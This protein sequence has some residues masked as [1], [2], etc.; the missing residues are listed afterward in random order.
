MSHTAVVIGL[1]QIGMGYDLFLQPERY[2]LTH[3]RAFAE[4]PAFSLIGGVDPSPTRRA[5][6]ER[7]YE[8]PSFCDP[9]AAVQALRPDV[10]A[11][12]VPTEHHLSVLTSTLAVH[13]PRL[14]LCEKPLAYNLKDSHQILAACVEADCKLFI[15]YLRRSDP[16]C[17]EVLRRIKTGD[18][19]LPIKGIAWYSK[20]L[21]HNGSHF[22]D[23]LQFWLGEIQNFQ[24]THSGR[25]F[26][27]NDIEPDVSISFSGGIVHFVATNEENFSH[28]TVELVAPNG[29][30]RYERGGEKIVWQS[31]HPSPV[32]D[33]SIL[34]EDEEFIPSDFDRIQWNVVDQLALA[35][36]GSP[37]S[38]CTGN[39]AF[40]TVEHLAAVKDS[41]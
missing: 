20:G 1:G 12:A 10:L 18:I 21:F 38:L 36:S 6:F 16:G 22:L 32:G 40:R 26:G 8:Q 13:K 9:V 17:Q 23:L 30:L 31:A 24:V 2:V 33:Y 11:V 7:I 14:V 5:D 29:R 41:L 19:R 27:S 34:G 28:Y 39:E 15:N 4:H 37:T 25:S 3:S 35:L